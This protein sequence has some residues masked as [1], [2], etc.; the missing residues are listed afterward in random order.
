MFRNLPLI[1]AQNRWRS[2]AI[3]YLGFS[4]FYL[5]SFGL[6]HSRATYLPITTWDAQFPRL[7]S[8]VWIYLSQFVLLPLAYGLEGDSRRL[9]RA[10]YAMLLATI[11]SC[12][13]FVA[14]PTTVGQPIATDH[15]ATAT[16][17]QLLYFFDVPGNCFPSLHVAL[18]IIAAWLLAGRGKMWMFLAPSWATAI[19]VSVLTTRQHRL[20]DI[21]GGISIAALS[22]WVTNTVARRQ[23]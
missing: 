16:A 7:P 8:S 10:Y 20:V 6:S 2:L 9:S 23:C 14:W 22:M 18:A 13:L 15:P 12:S 17:W 1:T 21:A 4:L 11:V 3:G 5:A 19:A